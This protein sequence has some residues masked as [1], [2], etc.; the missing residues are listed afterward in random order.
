[1]DTNLK[2]LEEQIMGISP[3]NSFEHAIERANHFLTLYDILHDT[4][5]RN[6]KNDWAEKFNKLMHWPKAE[7][8]VRIDGKDKQSTLILRASI[9]IDREHFT[10]NYLSELLRSTI[11]TSISALDRYTH[12]LIL[13][14]S[15]G[16][17]NQSEN[18]IP[19]KL[20]ELKIPLL[21]IKRALKKLKD[22]SSARPGHIIKKQIQDTLHQEYTFQTVSNIDTASKLLG[23]SDFWS[24][25]GKEMPGRPSPKIIQKGLRDIAKRRNQIVHEADLILKR[26]GQEITA[27]NITRKE[28]QSA[29]DWIKDFVTSIQKVCDNEL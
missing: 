10:H 21:T 16:L 11:V 7:E 23:I 2:L 15:W 3:Q 9:S 19:K 24:L 6:V 4:R 8:I 25:V 18:N 13:Y 12:D 14:H 28:A 22:D 29:K 17:L 5:K 27:R 1:M 20:K 26:K